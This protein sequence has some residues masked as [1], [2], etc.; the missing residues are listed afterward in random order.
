MLIA[1]FLSFCFTS[2]EKHAIIASI[3]MNGNAVFIPDAESRAAGASADGK[4]RPLARERCRF[5]AIGARYAQEWPVF[6]GKQSGT[7]K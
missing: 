1:A 3:V 6:A 4:G 5:P 2:A 7:A